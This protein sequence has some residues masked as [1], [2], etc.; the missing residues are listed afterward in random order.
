[1]MLKSARTYHK[2]LFQ[3]LIPLHQCI[4]WGFRFYCRFCLRWCL[5][6]SS[7]ERRRHLAS[8]L[9]KPK[10]LRDVIEVQGL[11]LRGFSSVVPCSPC[12]HIPTLEPKT[13][14]PTDIKSLSFRLHLT[15]SHS[16]RPNCNSSRSYIILGGS[17]VVISGDIRPLMFVISIVPLHITP[18]ITTLNPKP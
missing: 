1:M 9:Q 8:I 12:K 15:W 3:V 2:T 6:T 14:N 10:A 5:G 11:G 13:L 16:P 4:T 17:W 7:S 18:S